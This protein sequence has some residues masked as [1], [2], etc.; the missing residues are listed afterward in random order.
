MVDK[1][2]GNLVDMT[3]DSLVD[4][5]VDSLVDNLADTMVELSM[6][7]LPH[8]MHRSNIHGPC[9]QLIFYRNQIMLLNKQIQLNMMTW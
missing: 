8:K 1:T 3:A 7:I 9:I 2:A 4:T 6:L 5:T